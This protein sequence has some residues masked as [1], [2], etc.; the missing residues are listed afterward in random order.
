MVCDE[1]H[2]FVVEIIYPNPSFPAPLL[3]LSGSAARLDTMTQEELDS[4]FVSETDDEVS[5]INY[6]QSELFL[7]KRRS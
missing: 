4:F 2:V 7:L 1:L 3:P 6:S 5:M